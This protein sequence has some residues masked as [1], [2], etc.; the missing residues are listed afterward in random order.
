MGDEDRDDDPEGVIDQ[1]SPPGVDH[2][3]DA[4]GPLEALT[5]EQIAALPPD[6]QKLARELRAD[7]TKKTQKLAGDRKALDK[8]AAAV[9]WAEEVAR[10]YDEEGPE[11]AAALLR[12]AADEWHP[13]SRGQG[14]GA[15]GQRT[16]RSAAGGGVSEQ[17]QRILEIMGFTIEQVMEIEESGTP[18]ERLLLRS[19]VRQAVRQLETDDRSRKVGEQSTRAELTQTLT[20]LHEGEYKGLAEDYDAFET[21]VLQAAMELQTTNLK[22]AAKHAFHEQLVERR[23]QAKLREERRKAN[24]PDA[25]VSAG[26]G[27]SST[28]PKDFKDAFARAKAK[29]DQKRRQ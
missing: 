13:D 1:D 15:G 17:D 27:Q 4:P 16:S 12:A 22:A 9:T 24:L 23:V 10:M 29:L 18:N 25:E 11:A 14:P 6:A 3:Q 21:A 7:Y 5:E 2:D 28:K 8:R 19:Q 26:S 20:S